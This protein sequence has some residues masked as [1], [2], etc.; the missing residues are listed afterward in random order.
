MTDINA[1]VAQNFH[2]NI[3]YLQQH[4]PKVF[5][6]LSAFDI[7]V[8]NGHYK[9]K[10]ELIFENDNFDVLEHATQKFLYDK[11]TS[12]HTEKSLHSVDYSTENNCFEAFI[13]QDY[14]EDEIKDFKQLQ[15]KDP[16]ESHLPYIADIIH[17]TNQ[18]EK[19]LLNT[20]DKYIFFGVGLGLHIEAIAEHIQAKMYL[21]VEDDLELFRLSLFCI[22]YK[23]LAKTAKL[24]FAIFEDDSEFAHICENFLK[25]SYYFNHY[26][27]YFQ[28]LSH[29]EVKANHFYLALSSQ[30]E[31]KFLFHNYLR[32]LSIPLETFSQGYSIIEK[33]LNFN[34]EYFQNK[35]FLFIASGPSLQKNIDALL[36]NKDKFI[37]VAVSSS[38]NF[39]EKYQIQP[40]IV[41]HLDPFEIS[42]TPFER[43]DSLSFLDN[44]LIFLSAHASRKVYSLLNKENI[45]VFEAGSAYKT[46]ALNVSSSC[47]GSL[48]YLLLTVLKVQKLYFLGLDLAVDNETGSSH[49]N[50]HIHEKTLELKDSFQND[51]NETLSY[52]DDLVQ[53]KGNQREKVFTTPHFFTS[54]NLI[55][56]Y[57]ATIVKPSQQFYNLSDGAYFQKTQALTFKELK[58][59]PDLP[60]SIE[61]E[62]KTLLEAHTLHSLNENELKSLKRKLKFCKKLQSQL[63]NIKPN[64]TTPLSYVKTIQ[65]L[66]TG[67]ENLYKYELAR[68]L[69][70]YLYYILN[71]IYDYLNNPKIPQEDFQHIDQL[72]KQHLVE[73]IS[74]YQ[75]YLHKALEGNNQ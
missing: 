24:F 58:D 52:Y 64:N 26:I 13:R 45:Y 39:L 48:G 50:T 70:S 37:I 72:F 17:I 54:V 75:N 19:K 49:I 27:K 29:S 36:Q 53:I 33:N 40:H 9:E 12:Y 63:Q 2:E 14:T 30:A 74:V 51:T 31:L 35:P 71:F 25:E 65:Q 69:D 16:L 10:Y 59:L 55:N 56:N 1:K 11:Q 20:I 43:L 28:L 18:R 34:T 66:I 7:A 68:V 38:L 41:L 57:F 23:N 4:H 62:L 46:D 3:E 47:V 15:T 73:L 67:D 60:E 21:I 61:R 44:S 6:K 8:E 22:N 32:T 42:A 5:E